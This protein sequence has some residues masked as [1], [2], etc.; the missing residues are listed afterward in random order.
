MTEKN[1]SE[2]EI[3]RYLFKVEDVLSV[4]PESERNELIEELKSHIDALLVEDPNTDLEKALGEAKTYGS[5]LLETL[6]SDEKLRTANLVSTPQTISQRKPRHSLAYNVAKGMLIAF[7]TVTVFYILFFYVAKNE[8]ETKF[9]ELQINS[10]LIKMP[11]VRGQRA[12][13]GYQKLQ[14]ENIQICPGLENNMESKQLYIQFQAPSPGTLIN[15]VSQC[16]NLV[17]YSNY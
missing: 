16:A 14:S 4:L 2:M 8:L 3:Y 15:P 7:A 12:I 17:F 6:N 13:D 11:D 1:N 5:Q 9:N 10:D